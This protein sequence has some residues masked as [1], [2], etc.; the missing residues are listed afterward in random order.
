MRRVAMPLPSKS[1]DDPSNDPLGQQAE[2]GPLF[3]VVD[4]S[5]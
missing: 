3:G 2:P 1:V 5:A 4:L